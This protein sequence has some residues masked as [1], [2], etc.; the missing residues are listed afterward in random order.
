MAVGDKVNFE[1]PEY[2][3]EAFKKGTISQEH[4]KDGWKKEDQLL[5]LEID[6]TDYDMKVEDLKKMIIK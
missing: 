5:K 1:V 4:S 6:F 3:G 2:L